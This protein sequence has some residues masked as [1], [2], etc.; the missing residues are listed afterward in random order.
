MATTKAKPAKKP[1][2]TTFQKVKAQLKSI[3]QNETAS[4]RN[5]VKDTNKDFQR[6]DNARI[7][8]AVD[9]A[10]NGKKRKK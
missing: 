6:R 7:D 4:L 5:I 8:R 1:A 2:P 9:E 10:V 3:V